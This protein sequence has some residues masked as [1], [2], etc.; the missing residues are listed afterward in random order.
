VAANAPNARA[1]ISQKEI[2]TEMATPHLLQSILQHLLS[3]FFLLLL[4]AHTISLFIFQASR[5]LGTELIE[6]DYR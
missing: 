6:A 3:T 5:S 1:R 4:N 2:Q